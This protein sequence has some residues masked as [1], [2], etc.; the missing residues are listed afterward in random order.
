M[1]RW[2]RDVQLLPG[3]FGRINKQVYVKGT[4]T[5]SLGTRFYRS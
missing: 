3:K 1:G 4:T 2:T 5:K